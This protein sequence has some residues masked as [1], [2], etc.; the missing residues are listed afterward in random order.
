MAPRINIRNDASFVKLLGI[1][2][3]VIN[4]QTF[5]MGLLTVFTRDPAVR[6][7]EA[8]YGLIRPEW[9]VL[10]CLEYRDGSS[11][12]DI[13]E[14]TDQP[15]NTISRGVL[16]LERRGFLRRE[17]DTVDAR[18]TRLW[19]T[20]AGRDMYRA[21]AEQAGQVEKDVI[22]MLS[23]EES[24]QLDRILS[25]LCAALPQIAESRRQALANRD[26]GSD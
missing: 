3:H 7:L 16:A 13:C 2:D 26:D 23:S 1:I 14:I 24:A 8:Q 6:V 5:R 18:R 25:K 12:R 21:W 22:G 17:A 11:A 4:K 15:R 10:V 19:L 20:D 9:L